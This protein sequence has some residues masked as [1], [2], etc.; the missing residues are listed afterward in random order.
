[1]NN[2]YVSVNSLLFITLLTLNKVLE[3]LWNNIV[4]ILLL[5]RDKIKMDNNRYEANMNRTQIINR[6]IEHKSV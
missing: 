1:M 4:S 5:I 2:W 3:L 6:L